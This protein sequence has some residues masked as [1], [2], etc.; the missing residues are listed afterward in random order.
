MEYKAKGREGSQYLLDDP[1]SEAQS[2]G[3]CARSP[4][5]DNA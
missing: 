1:T 2:L 4:A 3:V 5:E